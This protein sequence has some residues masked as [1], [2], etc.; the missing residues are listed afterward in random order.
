MDF[1]EYQ[2][3][4]FSTCTKA[5][6]TAEYLRLGY[7]SE[8]GEVAGKLAKKIRGDIVTDE[9]IMLEI[10]DC[11]WMVAVDAKRL[12]E[13]LVISDYIKAQY[14]VVSMT[15]SF[16]KC[17]IEQLYF[18]LNTVPLL[19]FY[20]VKKSCEKLH[21]NFKKCLQMNNKKLASRK[22]RGKIRGNGDDR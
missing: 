4:A 3:K 16:P 15:A 11:A 17:P 19:R 10:G 1:T 9:C 7:I 2:E 21:L 5:C 22:A 20:A 18:F 6:Y 13:S 8:V 14:N 12:G